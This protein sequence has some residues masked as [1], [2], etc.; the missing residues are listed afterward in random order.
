MVPRITLALASLV[1]VASGI[2]CGGGNGK[3]PAAE[4]QT[5]S[6]SMLAWEQCVVP[7]TG[8]S[9]L[10]DL[11]PFPYRDPGPSGITVSGAAARRAGPIK[12]DPVMTLADALQAAQVPP[13]TPVVVWRCENGKML[14][15]RMRPDAQLQ[16]HDWVV[17]PDPASVY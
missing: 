2:G 8:D 3:P 13:N 1:L 17:A 9:S 7:V 16:V 5:S 12:N 6:A 14:A 15:L 10:R 11:P 4:G